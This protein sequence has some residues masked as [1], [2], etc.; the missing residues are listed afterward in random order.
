M[1]FEMGLESVD[2]TERQRVTKGKRTFRIPATAIAW[3]DRITY[4]T[5]VLSAANSTDRL[6]H[7]AIRVHTQPGPAP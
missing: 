1:H 7:D 3:A 4:V 5:Y 2:K 6:W